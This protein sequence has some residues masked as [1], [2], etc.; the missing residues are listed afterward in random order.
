M[1]FLMF[2]SLKF[3]TEWMNET[4]TEVETKNKILKMSNDSWQRI[5]EFIFRFKN[6]KF[7]NKK[8]SWDA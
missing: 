3:E 4:C 1:T 8:I 6:V 2:H 7:I 5:E